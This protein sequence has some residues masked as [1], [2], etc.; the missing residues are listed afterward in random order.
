MYIPIPKAS[1]RSTDNIITL[2][3]GFNVDATAIEHLY[4][5]SIIQYGGDDIWDGIVN[6][7]S[8]NVQIQMIQ[9]GALVTNDYWNYNYGAACDSTD[10][11]GE[12]LDDTGG[13]TG[14][15][16]LGYTILNTTDLCKGIA[17][18]NTNDQVTFRST[19][20]LT[21]GTNNYN[22][23]ADTYLL[24]VPLNPDSGQGISHRFMIKVRENGAD[25]D[26]RRLVGMCR[27]LGNTFAWFPI[28]GTSRGNNVLALSD[29]QDLNFDTSPQTVI[30]TTW[31]SEFS[32]EDL[33][34]QQFDVDDDGNDEDY[35]GKLTWTGSHDINDLFQ[36]AM[37]ETADH[38]GTG[39]DYTVHGLDGEVLRGVTHSCGYDGEA[40]AI[41]VSDYDML[42]WGT[43]IDHDVP[44]GSF[45]VGEVIV[46]ADPSGGTPPTFYA[47]ILSIDTSEDSMVVYIDSGTIGNTTQFWGITSGADAETTSDPTEVTNGGVLHVLANDD[48]NDI[49]YVQVLKGLMPGD[50]DVL[51]Y[52]GTSLGAADH[53][54]YLLV[55]NEVDT[56]TEYSLSRTAPYIG[57][58]TG[59]ALIGAHGVGVDND[60]GVLSATD[61]VVPL[62]ETTPISP[63]LSVT[64]TYS[65]LST[66]NDQIL[67]VATDGFTTDINGDPT[68]GAAYFTIATALTTGAEVTVTVDQDLSET[69]IDTWLP[70]SGYI[71]IVNDEGLVVDHVYS[72]YATGPN[73]FTIT[74]HDFS[75]SGVNDSVA[76]GNYCFVYQM[77]VVTTA[78]TGGAVT[79]VE[80]NAI[81]GS[82]PDSGTMRI[83]ND[84]GFHIRHPYSLYVDA[85]DIFTITSADFSGD[86]LTEQVSIGSGAYISYIDKAAAL[87]SETFAAVY[88]VDLNLTVVVRDGDGTPIK[89]D[90]K[91]HTFTNSNA[92]H[93]ITRT[94]DT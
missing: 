51:Y 41:V 91:R 12:Y 63:P 71:S 24:G 42:V 29:S 4:D 11:T 44:T 21:G 62:G 79:S 15:T 49:L 94:S 83:V 48:T 9:D 69:D 8:A 57:V 67:V 1:D 76:I 36:R 38:N 87:A 7:G 90:K 14:L 64:N 53:T 77:H 74:S 40:G 61:K 52:A 88:D 92:T 34:F 46:D 23:S 16:L 39:T 37:G 54:D 35:F 73:T 27:R 30:G 47:T 68:V 10:V 25:I 89:E 75:G 19:T 2:V 20:E 82:T 70:T 17:L 56:I 28:N 59:T 26:G 85:T 33:G 31:D 13:F 3:N 43:Y 72:G 58:S 22:T 32:G 78:L 6:F 66:T 45:A 5:G 18:S 81:P 84:D 93:G 60:P 55:A 65:G 86:G 50:D 80:V